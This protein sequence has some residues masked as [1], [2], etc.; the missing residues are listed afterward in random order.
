MYKVLI[1]CN[2]YNHSQFI[3]DALNGFC[4]QVAHFPFICAIVDDASTDG[5]QDVLNLYLKRHFDLDDVG[6]VRHAE[7]DDYVMTFARHRDNRNC[8][9]ALYLLKFNHLQRRKSKQPYLAEWENLSEYIALCEGDD[10]WTDSNKLHKQITFLDN[11]P[12]YSLCFHAA[13]E[14]WENGSM[15]DSLFSII[16]DRDYLGVEL[17]EKWIVPTAS[18]VLRTRVIHSSLYQQVK[19]VRFNRGD[20]PLFCTAAA[21]GRVRGMSDVMSVYRRNE[22]SFMAQPK[23]LD[24]I[25]SFVSQIRM[26]PVLFGNEFSRAAHQQIGYCLAN[27]VWAAIKE[28]DLGAA[29]QILSLQEK[30]DKP[31]VFLSFLSHPFRAFHCRFVKKYLMKLN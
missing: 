5:E 30:A 22:G 17:F 28:R 7:T 20:T 8:F 18:V 9:F 19:A 11:N 21:L 29:K 12:D 10:F 15:E 16:K 4:M 26:F 3:E 31:F 25:R 23:T 6:I 24:R 13:I 2:T 27:R 1:K 14:H